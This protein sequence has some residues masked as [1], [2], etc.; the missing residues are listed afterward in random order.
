MKSPAN[1][2]CDNEALHKNAIMMESKL[3]QKHNNIFFHL[4]QES[5]AAGKMVVL[6]VDGKENLADL[7]TIS[8]LGLTWKYLRS[9]IM[10]TKEE[11]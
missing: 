7:L 2:F 8:V 10:L 5:V 9:K 11:N 6:K 4:V 3:K 1:V